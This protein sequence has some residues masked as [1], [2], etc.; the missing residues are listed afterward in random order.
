M[1]REPDLER[2]PDLAHWFPWDCPECG[3]LGWYLPADE[4]SWACSC[5]EGKEGQELSD[6]LRTSW[7][8]R[9]WKAFNSEAVARGREEALS[10][11]SKEGPSA[12]LSTVEIYDE[13]GAAFVV[14]SRIGADGVARVGH[15]AVEEMSV[16][17]G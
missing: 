10:A 11:P 12:S 16:D 17:A 6:W 8:D 5:H 3:A 2:D 14:V 1:Q 15:L 4:M 13:A 9:W 7:L